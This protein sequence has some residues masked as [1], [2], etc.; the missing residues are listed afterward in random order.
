MGYFAERPTRPGVFSVLRK[1]GEQWVV[2]VIDDAKRGLV[3]SAV[4]RMNDQGQPVASLL[5]WYRPLA[6]WEDAV[7]WW[8]MGGAAMACCAD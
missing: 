3:A 2:I 1:N 6:Q 7:N 4:A 5:P 8:P